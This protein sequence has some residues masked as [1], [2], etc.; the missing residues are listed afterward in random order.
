MKRALALTLLLSIFV[1][2]V[3]R[4]QAVQIA[5]ANFFPEKP[6][7]AVYIKV[8]GSIEPATAPIKK[9]G[10]TYTLTGDIINQPIVVERDNIVIDGAGFTLQGNGSHSGIEMSYRGNVTVSNIHIDS[11]FHGVFS[12][13]SNNNTISGNTITGN[14]ES[15]ISLLGAGNCVISDN[16]VENNEDGIKCTGTTFHKSSFIVDN[17]VRYNVGVGIYNCTD[18]IFSGNVVE[19]N[20]VNFGLLKPKPTPT[21]EPTATPTP[22]PEPTPEPLPTS[23]VFTASVGTALLAIGLLVCFRKMKR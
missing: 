12:Y 4:L 23:L 13:N 17:I 21:P 9:V 2:L 15:G 14:S 8:K 18:N 11:F 6:P 5:E 3:T 7:H 16:L 19:N 20:G 10:N 1:L 22:T